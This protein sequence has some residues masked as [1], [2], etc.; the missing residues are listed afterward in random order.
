MINNFDHVSKESL[1]GTKTEQN[2]HTALSGESQAHVRYKFFEKKAKED[3]YVEISRLFCAIS[4]NEKEHAEIWFKYLG[5][6]SDTAE[7]L[8]VAASGEH[9]E[10][11]DMY[12]QFAKEAEEEGFKEISARFRLVAAI[13]RDHEEKYMAK[14]RSLEE[15]TVFSSENEDESWLCLN[16][17]HIHHGKNPPPICPT[18]RHDKGYFKKGTEL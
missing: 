4:E 1:A 14:L 10:W 7:N 17:G 11:S 5:G 9:F 15:N 13:E 18:C 6:V 12:S 3:G 8:K 2:L 16:C